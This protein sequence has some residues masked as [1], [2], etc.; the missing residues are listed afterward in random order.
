MIFGKKIYFY[1]S[2]I[3]S[4]EIIHCK[5]IDHKSHLK[6]SLSYLPCIVHREY[7]SIIFNVKKC[8]LYSIK[9]GI[10]VV[11]IFYPVTMRINQGHSLLSKHSLSSSGNLAKL[12]EQW[13]IMYF[14]KQ[15][16]NCIN[17]PQMSN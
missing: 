2:R 15:E 12:F 9:Y 10:S 6:P 17:L 1:F 11:H 16:N 3:I 8:T 7:F 4:K 5:F 14:T 13:N